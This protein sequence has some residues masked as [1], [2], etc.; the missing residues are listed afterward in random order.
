MIPYVPDEGHIVHMDFSPQAGREMAGPHYAVVLSKQVFNVGTGLTM[1]V[2]ITT[3]GKGSVFEIVVH[4]GRVK[5]YAVASGAKT[6]DYLERKMKYE[7]ECPAHTLAQIREVV[8]A[9]VGG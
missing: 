3:K 5:G 8:H 7:A 2:P 4:A 1:V 9:I 6:I